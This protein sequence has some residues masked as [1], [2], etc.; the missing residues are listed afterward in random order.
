[1]KIKN[2]KYEIRLPGCEEKGEQ[3]KPGESPHKPET[4]ARDL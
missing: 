3:I 4:V 2:P 1:M